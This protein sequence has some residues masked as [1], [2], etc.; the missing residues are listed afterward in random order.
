MIVELPA[1]PSTGAVTGNGSLVFG[2]GTQSN[3]SLSGATVLTLDVNGN[4]TTIFNTQS[5]P[6]FV[7][8]GSNGLFFLD[9]A[10]T[11]LA[12]CTIGSSTF[13]CPAST[14]NFTA[15]NRGLNG[16]STPVAFSV[17]NASLLLS[18]SN[19]NF[20]FNNLAAPNPGTFDWGLPFFF[21]RNVFIA[22][23]GQNTPGG[24]GPYTAY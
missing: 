17:A 21:G 16:Q 23:E 15:T 24:P 14:Q 10:T 5:V 12:T 4:F 22:I 2:I 8:A 13:Y 19:P 6:G 3:N 11:R 9:S 1:V 20:L 7:D 18:S